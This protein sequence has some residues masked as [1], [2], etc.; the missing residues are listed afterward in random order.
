VKS[1]DEA[2]DI[3]PRPAVVTAATLKVTAEF[4]GRAEIYAT[5]FP[6]IDEFAKHVLV[7]LREIDCNGSD[8]DEACN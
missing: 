3:A 2:D 6:T 7:R 1:G 4:E 5:T 8:K